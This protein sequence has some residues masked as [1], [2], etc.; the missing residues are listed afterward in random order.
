ML[1]PDQIELIQ[2][3]IDGRTTPAEAA[4]VHGVAI[5]AGVRGQVQPRNGGWAKHDEGVATEIDCQ[6]HRLASDL[7]LD[8][9]RAQKAHNG[10]H[11][12]ARR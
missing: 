8:H 5:G 2:R 3:D 12:C 6:P 1:Q 11:Q 10:D 9:R 7:R 4:A